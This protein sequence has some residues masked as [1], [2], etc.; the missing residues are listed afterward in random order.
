MAFSNEYLT[1]EEIELIKKTE[2]DALVNTHHNN[3]CYVIQCTTD[4][5]KKIW[6]VHYPYR[7][8]YE[9]ELNEEKFV[10][11]YGA[12]D[13][14]NVVLEEIIRKNSSKIFVSM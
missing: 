10:L 5:E 4:R 12:I 14:R 2:Q 1:Q 8:D 7:A 11:F 9:P 13:K 6:L 3:F